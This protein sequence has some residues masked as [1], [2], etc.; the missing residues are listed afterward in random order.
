MSDILTIYNHI[1][2]CMI[3]TLPMVDPNTNMSV[4]CVIFGY[5][6]IYKEKLKSLIN[7]DINIFKINQH[8]IFFKVNNQ[9]NI[10]IRGG[11][12]FKFNKQI[13]QE[14]INSI[15]Y[16]IDK[17][18]NFDQDYT[19]IYNNKTYSLLFMNVYFDSAKGLSFY[20]YLLPNY[21]NNKVIDLINS[22]KSK[23]EPFFKKMHFFER[24][25][26]HNEKNIRCNITIEYQNFMN[27]YSVSVYFSDPRK[28]IFM[29]FPSDYFENK[30]LE[31]ENHV[32]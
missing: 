23:K 3:I 7:G 20:S 27:K 21:D 26:Y 4:S 9:I 5:I 10:V 17:N 14:K 15:N 29:Y 24:K 31:I 8:E 13:F 32:Q 12:I 19:I 6:S 16:R 25:N 30:L 18:S 28:N 2:D 1:K 11:E 22:F